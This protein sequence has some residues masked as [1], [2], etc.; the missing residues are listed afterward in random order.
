MSSYESTPDNRESHNSDAAEPESRLIINTRTKPAPGIYTSTHEKTGEESTDRL[1]RSAGA[2]AVEGTEQPRSHLRI[3]TR[4]KPDKKREAGPDKF[5]FLVP[6][7]EIQDNVE[8]LKSLQDLVAEA[9]SFQA[10]LSGESPVSYVSE[11]E[12]AVPQA[13]T[14]QK[15]GIFTKHS[16]HVGVSSGADYESLQRTK[17]YDRYKFYSSFDLTTPEKAELGTEWFSRVAQTAHERELSLTVKRADHAYDSLNLYTWHPEGVAAIVQE[18]YPEFEAC[19]L[20][21]ETPHFFQG[22]IEGINSN[23]VGFVQEP[24]AAYSTGSH[25]TR[26]SYLGQKIDT[27]L[28]KGRDLNETLFTEAAQE[29]GVDP[30][31]PYILAR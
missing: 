18:L 4:T 24:I 29:A 22:E 21:R 25:S 28:A 19:G 8:Y 16:N 13:I 15:L 23:H 30:L 3:R 9:G 20:Y 1:T 11:G 6:E 31:Y 12:M 26:M 10:L 14:L 5:E 27:E 2:V 17:P 7:N